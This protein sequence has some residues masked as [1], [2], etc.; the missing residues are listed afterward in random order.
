MAQLAG[1]VNGLMTVRDRQDS[2]SEVAFLLVEKAWIEGLSRIHDTG[3]WPELTRGWKVDDA[4][5][6]LQVLHGCLQAFVEVDVAEILKG[7]E[8]IGLHASRKT[9]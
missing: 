2:L 9:A 4:I 6:A 8:P 7:P 1:V 5:V 3:K